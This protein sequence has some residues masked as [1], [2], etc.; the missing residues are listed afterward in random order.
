MALRI[1]MNVAAMNAHR[2]LQGTDNALGSSIEKL[3]SGYKINRDADSPAG[4]A[5]SEN[6]RAQISGLGQAIS[7]SNDAVNMIKT[8]EGAMAEVHSL[9]RTM[10]DLAVHAAQTGTNDTTARAADQTQVAEIMST[11]DNIASNTAFGNTK[12][13]DGTAQS[14][15]FQ[16]GAN[17]G[18]TIQ[19]SIGSTKT[20]AVDTAGPTAGG[21]NAKVSSVTL[22][23]SSALTSS[24]TGVAQALHVTALGTAATHTGGGAA[25]VANSDVVRSAGNVV[26]NGRTYVVGAADKVSDVMAQ[27]NLDTAA[28]GVTATFAGGK[29][30][31]TQATAGS[32][33]AI[34]YSETADILNGGA[35]N[36]YIAY[37]TNAQAHVVSAGGQVDFNLGYGNTLQ[38][39]AGDQIVL[40]GTAVVEDLANAFT[41]TGTSAGEATLKDVSAIDVSSDAA[42]A[43][44]TLDAAIGRVSTMRASLGAKMNSL[45]SNMN[46]LGVAKENIAAS[47]SSIRDTDM[48]EEMVNFTRSQ[49]LEQAGV[50]ML[51]QANQAPQAL[52]KLLG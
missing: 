2:Q 32:N 16:I 19:F 33:K 38:D 41:M 1:N 37:G 10:R 30:V 25:Y 4:L 44:T 36:N 24:S 43:L 48:A 42:T 8:A 14:L 49:I 47:E 39:A 46:S 20:D 7:N 21:L 34:A 6:L 27:I 22:G 26:V 23:A 28:N 52:L 9:L 51:A 29:V 45:Q 18:E 13:L 17:S 5:I 12:L 50:S 35:A 11:L 15:V 3:S 40:G 31:L